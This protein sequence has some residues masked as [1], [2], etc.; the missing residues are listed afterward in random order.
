[1]SQENVDL[2]LGQFEAVNARD[3]DAVLDAWAEDV[4]L[5]T[6]GDLAGLVGVTGHN[7]VA[8]KE[9]VSDWYGDWFRQFARDYRFE[10]DQVHDLGDR[11]LIVATHH[12]RGRTSG[13]PV[14][15]RSGYLYTVREGKVSRM[16]LWDDGNDALEA[17]GLRE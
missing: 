8:G 13:V 17:A 16:E 3:F 6:H 2:V 5:L 7:A 9:A 14:T 12:A 10:I 4:T 1:M 11:V 15:I